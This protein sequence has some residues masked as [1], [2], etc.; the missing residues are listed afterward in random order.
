MR[1]GGSLVFFFVSS[2]FLFFYPPDSHSLPSR[3]PLR[4]CHCLCLLL[5]FVLVQAR[6]DAARPRSSLD[7]AQIRALLGSRGAT[8]RDD[9]GDS[10][11]F[12]GDA[13]AQVPDTRGAP[14]G[15]H[16]GVHEEQQE[17]QEEQGGVDDMS[18]HLR[19]MGSR[20][21]NERDAFQ[22]RRIGTGIG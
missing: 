9:D 12:G 20:A 3:S 5:C 17:E 7:A 1:S 18:A 21:G 2:L 16:D 11:S 19:G 10:V 13:E 22:V 6:T 15:V 4:L 8:G 14:D